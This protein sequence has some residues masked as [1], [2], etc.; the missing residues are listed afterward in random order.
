[1]G[2]HGQAGLPRASGARR[3]S[4]AEPLA[5]NAWGESVRGAGD[6]R[7]GRWLYTVLW[8]IE[9]IVRKL[10]GAPPRQVRPTGP[11]D[12][13]RWEVNK[14]LAQQ[15]SLD[16]SGIDVEVSNGEV[17]LCGTTESRHDK[18]VAEEIA[19]D[20]SGVVGVH[21]HLRVRESAGVLPFSKSGGAQ[22]EP[23]KSGPSPNRNA[24]R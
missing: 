1:M 13:I 21:N 4:S 8:A 9:R 23:H 20:V 15:G 5:H 7:S 16:P 3:I 14:R 17:T 10:Q 18:Y 11:D 22:G 24:R 12:C 6:V 2:S 19:D